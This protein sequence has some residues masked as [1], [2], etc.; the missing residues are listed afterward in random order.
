MRISQK[1]RAELYRAIHNGIVDVRIK[2]KLPA[3]E[4][5]MLAQVESEIWRNQKK[6][7][8]IK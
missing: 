4:D 1:R 5:V 8:D 2:L 7:L 3:K 6:T